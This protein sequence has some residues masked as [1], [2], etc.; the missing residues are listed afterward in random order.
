MALGWFSYKKREDAC[1]VYQHVHGGYIKM[2][3][4]WGI[5][6]KNQAFNGFKFK[7]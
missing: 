4:I 6:V 2:K 5:M 3:K 1:L 7:G